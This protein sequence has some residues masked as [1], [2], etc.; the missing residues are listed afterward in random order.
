MSIFNSDFVFS[1]LGDGDPQENV[2]KL[3][4]V[5]QAAG[6]ATQARPGIERTTLVFVR[7][8]NDKFAQLLR[9]DLLHGLQFGVTADDDSLADRS[10][11]IYRYLTGPKA[12]KGLE[13]VAGQGQWSFIKKAMPVAGYL[14]GKNVAELGRKAALAPNLSTL[15]FLKL[16]GSEVALYFEFLKFYIGALVFLA[17]FGIMA[18]VKSKQYSMTFAFVNLAWTVAVLLFWRR[19]ERFLTNSW[20][21]QNSHLVE[22]YEAELAQT[23]KSSSSHAAKTKRDGVRIAKQL[24]FV[25]V[26][27]VFAAVLLSYQLSCFILEI[28]LTEIYDGPGKMFLSLVPIVLISAFVPV[29]SIAFR[30]VAD[31]FLMWENHYNA[32]H[33]EESANVKTF[34]LN[35]LTSYA[36]LLITSFIYL[37]FAHLIE[38]YLPIIQYSIERSIRSD[39]YMYHYL[40]KLKSQKEFTYNQGRLNAQFFYFI[41]TNQVIQ[42]VLKYALPLIISPALGFVKTKVLGKREPALPEDDAQEKEWLQKVRKAIDLPEHH[43]SED[44]RG[45]AL[46]FGYLSLF[47]PVWTLAPLVCIFFNVVTFKLDTIKLTSGLYVSPSVPRRV[48]SIHPWDVAFFVL[49]WIGS[50]VSPLVTAFYRH[51][52]KP[53]KTLGQFALKNASVNVSSTTR[54]MAVLFASEHLFFALYFVGSKLLSCFKSDPE[55]KN[56]LMENDAESRKKSL[57]EKVESKNITTV[58]SDWKSLPVDQVVQ[59]AEVPERQAASESEEKGGE[60]KAPKEKASSTVEESG[61][62]T[63]ASTG[64]SVA[65]KSSLTNRSEK[66]SELEHKRHVLEEKKKEL[67][68]KQTLESHLNSGDLVINVVSDSG[69]SQK[70]IIDGDNHISMEDVRAIEKK[71]SQNDAEATTSSSKRT[72]TASERKVASARPSHLADSAAKEDSKPSKKKSLKKMFKGK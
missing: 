36:P 30:I 17:I 70:A 12:I 26:A 65:D 33:R 51:G 34:T 48:D 69:A 40:T 58:S 25:P 20:G 27:L 28:F 7:L 47:G 57:S 45:L 4:D 23:D 44:F 6:F 67:A 49:A 2:A 41:V 42:L 8:S 13:I 35:F 55:A 60:S 11:A 52:T 61:S 54:L 32:D 22:E 43:A 63:A 31:K 38:P 50:I 14:A 5:L 10:R 59:Q 56:I 18:S 68:Q 9:N 37:P 1:I 15:L 29:L 21:L 71:L 64:V 24:A 19:R 3:V 46:Q 62:G 72:S 16:F 66:L 53:P 39:R